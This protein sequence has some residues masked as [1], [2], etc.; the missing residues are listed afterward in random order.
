MKNTGK[1]WRGSIGDPAYSASEPVYAYDAAGYRCDGIGRVFTRHS[2]LNG[3]KFT[4]KERDTE[5]GLDYFGA[6][7]YASSMGRW[8]SPDWSAKV[9][10]V[11]YAKL[12]NP[13]SL[14]LY[15]YVLNNPLVHRDLDGHI[16]DETGLDKNKKY[17]Q[18]KKNYLS[19]EG[20]QKQW[21]A[22]NDNKN[23]TVHMSWDSKGSSSVTS[24]YQWD[25]A[26]NLTSVNVSLAGKTG[27]TSNTMNASSGYIHGS[28]M[29][30]DGAMRQAY[31][32][33]HEFAH[34]EYADTQTGGASIRNDQIMGQ[35]IQDMYNQFGPKLFG[36]QPGVEQ[37][38]QQLQQDHYDHEK[39]ADQRAWEVI[40][41]PK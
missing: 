16:I 5:S 34:V 1:R 13:Q 20:A 10:P 11:P 12:D 15:N 26:G 18:W 4:G 25:K 3:Y 31:V 37:M 35:H 27:D 23:L 30:N 41:S 9:Q 39:G 36:S 14:N 28:T 29:N 2:V 6:R 38:N 17:Q 19:H 33:A 7:Y 24:G 32:F 22:L 8:M 40:G 21:N